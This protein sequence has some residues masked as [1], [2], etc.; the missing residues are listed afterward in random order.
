M[1]KDVK[2]KILLVEDSDVGI[3]VA[4]L[5][6]AALGCDVDIAKTSHDALD[7]ATNKYDLIFMDIGLDEMDGYEVTKKIR[8]SIPKNKDTPII[9]LT[10]HSN[11]HAKDLCHAAGMNDFLQKPLTQENLKIILDKWL[12]N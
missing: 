9:A 6:F 3:M 5:N 11:E 7:L 10:A 2:P 8:A 4:K 1:P 12:P